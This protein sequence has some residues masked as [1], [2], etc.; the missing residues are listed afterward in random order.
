MSRLSSIRQIDTSSP[1]NLQRDLARLIQELVGMLSALE[2][3]PY[4]LRGEGSPEGVRAAPVGSIYLRTDGGT[5]STL[6]VKESGGAGKTGWDA[7]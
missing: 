4:A 2:R 5:S 3:R 6:Y 1:E 7:K